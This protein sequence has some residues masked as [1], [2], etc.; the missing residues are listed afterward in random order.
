MMAKTAGKKWLFIAVPVAIL[1]IAFFTLSRMDLGTSMVREKAMEAVASGTEASLEI[2]AVRGNPLKG[3]RFEGI[4]LADAAGKEVFRAGRLSVSITLSSL[5]SGRPALSEVALQEAGVDVK[6]LMAVLPEREESPGMEAVLVEFLEDGADLRV[7]VER[8]RLT[9]S[10]VT[11]GFGLLEVNEISL[12]LKESGADA[13]VALSLRKLPVS[14]RGTLEWNGEGIR[15]ASL[16]L[17]PGS[18]KIEASGNIFPLL[19]VTGG[20]EN[21]DLAELAALWPELEDR[22]FA[23]KF[24]TT[25]KAGGNWKQPVLYGDL[26]FSGGDISGFTLDDASSAWRYEAAGRSLRMEDVRAS[27]IGVPV[28]GTMGFVFSQLPP[29]LD[30]DLKAADVSLGEVARRFPALEDAEGNVEEVKVRLTGRANAIRGNVL[31]RTGE[32]EAMG[33]K[34]GAGK[35]ELVFDGSGQGRFTADST[36]LGRPV[37]GSG[38]FPLAGG[39]PVNMVLEAPG[40]PL[41]KLA[42]VREELKPL[43]LQGAAAVRL[44]FSGVPGKDLGLKGVMTSERLRIMGELFRNTKA[45]VTTDEEDLLLRSLA[46]TWNEA[47]IG[48]SGRVK[49]L[50]SGQPELALDATLDDLEL[51]NLAAFLPAL[52]ENGVKGRISGTAQV[53]GPV[54][55][56]VTE[57]RLTSPLIQAQESVM[58]KEIRAEGKIAL[59]ETGALPLAGPFSLDAG[60]LNVVGVAIVSPS[61]KGELADDRLELQEVTAAPGG[62]MLKASGTV[63]VAA[64]PVTLSLE[65]SLDSVEISQTMPLNV[66]IPVSGVLSGN[67]S[68]AGD[69]SEPRL[70]GDLAVPALTVSG[71]MFNDLILTFAGT[72]SDFRIEPVTASVGDAPLS[73]KAHLSDGEVPVVDFDFL[74]QKLDLASLASGLEK[75]SE[76]D[77]KG[78]MDLAL[79]GT[80]RDGKL[81]GTGGISAPSVEAMGISLTDL[82]LPV[83]AENGKAYLRDGSA[84][85]YGGSVSVTGEADLAQLSWKGRLEVKGADLQPVTEALMEDGASLSG[86]TDFNF[87]GNGNMKVGSLLGSGSLSVGEGQLKGLTGLDVLAK[88]HGTPTLGYRSILSNYSLNSR[89]LELLPG[90]RVLAP[91]G[92]SLYRYL[93]ADGSL[94]LDKSLDLGVSGNVNVQALNALLGG[95]QGLFSAAGQSPEAMLE[96]VLGG[97]TGGLAEKDFRDVSFRLAGTTE[98][99]QFKDLKIQQ[100]IQPA[101]QEIPTA[102][103]EIQA[104]PEQKGPS[105]PEEVLQKKVLEKLFGD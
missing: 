105:S 55:S 25:F 56:P 85:F 43:K 7:P 39:R 3:Y 51:E 96:G 6:G 73:G 34:L 27:L 37:K 21:L 5:F 98:K 15:L 28:A 65:G 30:I 40:V 46:S 58:A 26:A 16:L 24:G 84:A 93:D 47:R 60:T 50:T 11:T 97:L 53:T 14:G 32:I 87:D 64:E 90:T 62:G 42:E 68:V 74:G 99:P 83:V 78:R 17:E 63:G 77:V 104:A 61:L 52:A 1:V 19:A 29:D 44:V 10:T 66:L 2:D 82:D 86:K 38:T 75:A 101:Q 79:K 48:A 4:R 9:D 41:N 49:A 45:E 94:G 54:A 35:A 67:F 36:W 72:P 89:A 31:V 92:D 20:M 76:L 8:V 22:G 23:G 57:F 88:L 102:G 69:V 70:G 59:R 95:L 103:S 91:E 12:R 13:D 18:G 71:M 33:Q 80:F 81:K 100:K